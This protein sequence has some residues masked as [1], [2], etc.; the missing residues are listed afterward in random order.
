MAT[1]AQMQMRVARQRRANA[2]RRARAL[3][4]RTRRVTPVRAGRAQVDP[5]VQPIY[6]T[7]GTAA[8]TGQMIFFQRP[9]GQSMVSGGT[10]TLR[11]TNMRFGGALPNPRVQVITGFRVLLSQVVGDIAAVPALDANPSFLFYQLALTGLY[12]ESVFSFELGNKTYTQGPT[13]VYPGNAYVQI[14]GNATLDPGAG[15]VANWSYSLGHT[16]PYFSTMAARIKVGPLQPFNA[17]LTWPTNALGAATPAG[18]KITV[19]CE[20]IQGREIS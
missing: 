5:I 10:K 13:W 3:A 9:V 15:T 8:F 7:E 19:V 4:G 20:G 16:G 2:Q 1:K 6:D 11:D 17:K 12:E 18:N 14:S